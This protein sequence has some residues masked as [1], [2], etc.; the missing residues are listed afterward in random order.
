MA[1][2]VEHLLRATTLTEQMLHAAERAEWAQLTETLAARDKELEQAF[3]VENSEVLDTSAKPLLEKL[4][5]LNQQVEQ[6]CRNAKQDLATELRHFNKNKQAAAAY[7][8]L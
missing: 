4:I 3:S 8:S 6:Y 2:P 1:T 5:E 7:K